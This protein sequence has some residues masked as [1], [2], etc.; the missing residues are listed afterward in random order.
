MHSIIVIGPLPPCPRCKLLTRVVSAKV[1]EHGVSASVR[2]ISY[3]D[4][5]AKGIAA[6]AG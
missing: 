1:I 6:L 2:H 5:E 4:D 3:T